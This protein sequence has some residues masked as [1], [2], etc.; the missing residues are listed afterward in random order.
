MLNLPVDKC[1]IFVY[2]AV[3]LCTDLKTLY[4]TLIVNI[5]ALLVSPHCCS[6]L[7]PPFTR[8]GSSSFKLHNIM[9]TSV[10]LWTEKRTTFV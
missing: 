9:H 3:L 2:S 6:P 7:P 4:V 8:N 1:Y 5:Q 10:P